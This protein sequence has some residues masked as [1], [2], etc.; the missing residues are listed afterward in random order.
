[1][2]GLFGTSIIGTNHLTGPTAATEEKAARFAR[3]DLVQGKPVLQDLGNEAGTKVLN[4]F[5]DETFC[6]PEVEIRKIDA[7]FKARVP[8]K[9]YL[10]LIGFEVGVFL[11]ERLHIETQQ[12]TR[13]GRVV[14]AE[15]EVELIEYD[16]SL[17]RIVGAAVGLARAIGNPF[18]RRS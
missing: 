1:M 10:D 8:L 18:V 7:A 6:E 15:L 17:N 12:T 9:L 16:G 11:I 5:F 4:F 2:L 13:T 3:H 14:R